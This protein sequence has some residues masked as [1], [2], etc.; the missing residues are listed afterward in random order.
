VGSFDLRA[1]LSKE[2][3][4]V[5]DSATLEL[6]VSG[7][8][9]AQMIA[10]PPLPDL[11]AF[12]VYDDKPSGSLGRDGDALAGEKTFRKA[13]V[14]LHAGTLTVPPVELTFFD[15]R[16]GSYRTAATP[17]LALEVAP[18]AGREELRLTESVA[19]TTGKVAVKILADDILPL[20]KGLDALD[21]SPLGG[22]GALA[23]WT[24]AGA[25]PPLAFLA[26]VLLRRRQERFRLDAGLR[27]RRSAL[28]AGLAALRRIAAEAG[29]GRPAAAAELA[30]RCL[31]GFVGDKLGLEGSALTAAETD[32]VLRRHG[33]DEALVRRTHELLDRLEAARYGGGA[34]T[35]APAPA[36]AGTVAPGQRDAGT[37]GLT[38]ALEPLLRDLD[39]ALGSGARRPARRPEKVAASALALL[40]AALGAAAAGAPAPGAEGQEPASVADSAPALGA[41]GDSSP[42]PASSPPGAT[43]EE[44][45]VHAAA[46]YEAGDYPRALALYR[47]LREA[48]HGDG[49]LDYD[50]GNAYLRNGELGKAIAAYLRAAAALPRD[51]DVRAN[52]AFAR[53]SA[54]DALA[55]PAPSPVVATLFFWHYGLGRA[56]LAAAAA[57]LNLLFW[58]FL[59]ARLWRRRSE[60]LRWAAIVTLILLA[61]VGSSLAV[62]LLAPARVA[63]VVPQEVDVR[64]GTS[65]DTVV[66]FKLHAGT[67]V[68]ALERREGWLRIALPDGQQGWLPREHAEL[69]SR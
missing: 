27:R 41:A 51:Q 47:G 55:P 48:G 9:N 39:R 5:G 40:L 44:A 22:A 21:R 7:T 63:V 25:A 61:A 53:K 62:H 60:A 59:A 57:A 11:A 30:S 23:L 20:Y 36:G 16:S 26:L 68:R 24:A 8:G 12:K 64:S 13:L 14:P 15:P 2:R 58:G 18:A 33:V 38:A 46:A 28:R 42:D 19:P 65:A 69:V 3:L 17:P 56:E 1:R 4:A 6:T 67:E 43:P 54:K 29:G 52:L 32:A 49:H 45:F 37:E 35:P 34:R 50:L 66:R 31:R 10:E